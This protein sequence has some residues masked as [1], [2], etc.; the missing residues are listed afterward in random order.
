MWRECEPKLVALNQLSI[1][2]LN[3]TTLSQDLARFNVINCNVVANK[4]SLKLL[5]MTVFVFSSENRVTYARFKHIVYAV[6][7]IMADH[8]VVCQD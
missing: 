5:W 1:L 3:S 4:T 7:S 2:G 6:T 8:R